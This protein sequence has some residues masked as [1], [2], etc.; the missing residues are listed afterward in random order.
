MNT[1]TAREIHENRG[2]LSHDT[3]TFL[4]CFVR[5]RNEDRDKKKKGKRPSWTPS[6][7]M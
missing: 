1:L 6:T 5:S 4:G 3:L 7:K 2:A